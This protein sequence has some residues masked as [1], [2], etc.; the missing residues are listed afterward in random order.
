M[1]WAE[2]RRERLDI[3]FCHL[4]VAPPTLDASEDRKI[5]TKMACHYRY[6]CVH[7]QSPRFIYG[8][9]IKAF[10]IRAF[11]LLPSELLN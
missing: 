9:S 6:F 2:G 10:C 8:V 1:L 3:A 7:I 11:C 5:C 4:V